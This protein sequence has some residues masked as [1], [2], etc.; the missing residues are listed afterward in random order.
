M[1]TPVGL[2]T[3]ANLLAAMVDGVVMVVKAEV[4]LL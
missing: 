4:D 1:I 2:L 3:D